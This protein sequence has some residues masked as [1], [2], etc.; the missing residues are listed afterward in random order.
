M[1]WIALQEIAQLDFLHEQSFHR[2]QLILKHSTRCSISGV[3]HTRLEKALPEIS[4]YADCYYLDLLSYRSI[5]NAVAEKFSV[6]HESPQVLI[7][8]NGECIFEESHLQIQPAE[9][10]KQILPSPV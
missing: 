4:Q 8:R 7:M 10:M 1:S 6:F 5:S 9:I 3:A 2:P